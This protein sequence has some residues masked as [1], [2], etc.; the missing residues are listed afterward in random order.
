[1]LKLKTWIPLRQ[2]AESIA[3]IRGYVFY[4]L[5]LGDADGADIVHG[6]G[7]S[8]YEALY[9][10]AVSSDL[11]TNNGGEE[12]ALVSQPLLHLSETSVHVSGVN[13]FAYVV[14]LLGVSYAVI[15]VLVLCAAG[16]VVTVDLVQQSAGV[17]YV[18]D[19]E[20]EVA[21][22][23]QSVEVSG[24]N[25]LDLNLDTEVLHQGSLN[26][27]SL[28]LTCGV[29]QDLDGAGEAQS[30]VLSLCSSGIISD[31]GYGIGVTDSS[32]NNPV[33]TLYAAQTT[34][35]SDGKES[36]LIDGL[37][38]SLTGI[39]IGPGITTPVEAYEEAGGTSLDVNYYVGVGL[40]SRSGSSCYFEVYVDFAGFKSG[41]TGGFLV[42]YLEYEGLGG[43]VF[44]AAKVSS[45][46]SMVQDTPASRPA[47]L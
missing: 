33:F 29:G 39:S 4:S 16:S 11:V 44:Y 23:Q 24:L 32:G 46:R 28:G 40:Q 25:D 34:F 35:K 6:S 13:A 19:E 7:N 5:A 26:G 18:V 2:G 47:H 37:C 17:R 30:F 9:I 15:A 43:V 36:V 21:F 31:G 41:C 14:G 12:D 27:L 38:Y 8:I 10:G 1:M 42:D 3:L 20:V 22:V 45:K